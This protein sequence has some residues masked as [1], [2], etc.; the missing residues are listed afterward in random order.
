MVQYDMVLLSYVGARPPI[1]LPAKICMN[2]HVKVTTDF[3][4]F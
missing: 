3:A 4:S 1:F 2:S